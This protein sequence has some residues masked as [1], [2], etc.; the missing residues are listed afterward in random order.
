MAELWQLLEP[1]GNEEDREKGKR[2]RLY[3]RVIRDFMDPFDIGEAEFI[4]L[5]R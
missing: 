1:E 3:C 4:R 2:L 5:Y